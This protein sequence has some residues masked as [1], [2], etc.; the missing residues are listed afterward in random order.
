MPL[1]LATVVL[2][3]ETLHVLISVTLGLDSVVLVESLGFDELVD[4][5]ANEADESLFGEGVGDWLAYFVDG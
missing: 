1:V 4:F 5:S 3:I 2:F